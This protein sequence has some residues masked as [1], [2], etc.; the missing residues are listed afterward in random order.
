MRVEEM[1]SSYFRISHVTGF[2]RPNG[3]VTKRT[4]K[5]TLLDVDTEQ[6]RLRL[7]LRLRLR[8]LL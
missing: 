7:R 2:L 5:A 1:G 3:N 6:Q 4:N 8:R